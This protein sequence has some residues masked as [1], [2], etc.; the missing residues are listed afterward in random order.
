VTTAPTAKLGAYA[1]LAAF[2]LLA[3]L[4]LRLP[5]LAAVTAPLALVAALGLVLARPP[6]LD[7]ALVLG[8]ER[9]LEGE[10][11]PVT[12]RIRARRRVE[13]L[14]L[15]VVIPPGLAVAEGESVV[16]LRLEEGEERELGLALRGER[17]GAYAV[18]ELYLRAT[19][20]LGVVRH[21]WRLDRRERLRVYPR[22]EHLTRLLR[23]LETQV[24]SGNQV[25]RRRGDG[26][27]F[28][29]LRP[30]VPGDRIRRINWR[31][32]ARTGE[33]WVN[34][35]HPERNADVVLFLDSFAELRTDEASTLDFAVRAAAGFADAYLREKDRVGVVSFGGRLNW[36]L[37]G[38]GVAQLYRIL[39]TVLETE[40]VAGFVWSD[41]DLIPRRTLPPQA[42]VLA[43]S[44]LLDE[45]SSAALLDLRARG[46]DLA[47]VEVS[48]R[49]FV[50]P[51]RGREAALAFR[52]WELRRDVVRARFRRA[53]IAVASW[54][55]ERPVVGV[56]EEVRA[57]RRHAARAPA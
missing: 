55:G 11:V 36:L 57:F 14:E 34:D 9:A 38:T 6:A 33:L 23:P 2:G 42:L 56:L 18:G 5:E 8:R 32:S 30:F 49:G 52:I 53:G 4:A 54:D 39:D 22:P 40:V 44:P 37:P 29:D 17:W 43:L 12:L 24:F 28:A 47:V 7:V 13:R 25:S 20:P 3:G 10:D 51:G 31:A 26:V 41:V 27:E 45:R 50:E 35:R 21:E 46:F 15:L 19:Q 48:P 16:A 1:G